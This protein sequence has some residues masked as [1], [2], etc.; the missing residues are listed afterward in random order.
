MALA[1]DDG[2]VRVRDLAIG[3]V[4]TELLASQ[5]F[6]EGGGT[7]NLSAA[8]TRLMCD[9]L[10]IFHGGV[11][12]MYSFPPRYTAAIAAVLVIVGIAPCYPF[13][14]LLKGASDRD[15]VVILA[16]MRGLQRSSMGVSRGWAEKRRRDYLG[17]LVHLPPTVSRIV[18]TEH[19]DTTSLHP[20]WRAGLID[21]TEPITPAELLRRES[22]TEDRVGGLPVVISP[23]GRCFVFLSSK[24]VAELETANRQ[25]IARWVGLYSRSTRPA[26]SK[27]LQEAAEGVR[28]GAQITLAV[29]LADVFDLEGVR[30]R[31]K[32]A[33]A[34]EGKRVD[35]EQLAQTLIGIRGVKLTL[36]VDKEINGEIRLDFS[37]S[38]ESL[39]GV[40]KE[41]V[42][43]AMQSMG[44]SLD[45]LDSWKGSVDDNAFLLRGQLTEQGARMLLS[46][47]VGRTSRGPYA[48]I[49]TGAQPPPN[50]KAIPSQQYF[51]SVTSLLDELN[52][53]KKPKN[54]SQRGYW[55][56][57]Y[58]GKIEA[59]PILNVDPELLEFGTAVS[60]TLR[61]MANLGKA[62]KDQNAM[63]QANQINNLALTV[64]TTYSGGGYGYTP[65]GAGGY[66]WNYTVPQQVEVSNYRAVGNLCSRMRTRRRLTGRQPG[67]TSPR[68]HRQFGGKWSRSTRSNSDSCSQEELPV[69]EAPCPDC[70]TGGP[71][72][73]K[74]LS[75]F[76][77]K[78]RT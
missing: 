26:L 22:G 9:L 1:S 32:E 20:T 61:G 51:R 8:D 66:G 55:Y 29:D 15:N 33:K 73:R 62:V 54:I 71:I 69:P 12:T 56:Q 31:L 70:V 25:E 75:G 45:D 50:P 60:S 18:V 48:D 41:L 38:A 39:R 7:V 43:H 16:N 27:Y 74:Q 4:L 44:A 10:R 6:H 67:R 47:V 78:S 17:G 36:E 64:P 21:L 40:G 13:E 42:L 37:G 5:R 46:P 14:D 68:P 76:E 72:I 19:L 77:W 23:R 52:N 3:T 58:A 59:L 49:T 28:P 34:L 35:P 11:I 30:K 24:L 53:E 2:S 63:I 65:W 57:Q